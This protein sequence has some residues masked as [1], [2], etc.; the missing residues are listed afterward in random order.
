MFDSE[1]IDR[2][3]VDLDADRL[4]RMDK[5]DVDVQVL[6]LTTPAVQ[7]LAP[8]ASVALARD[9]NDLIAATVRRRPDRFDGFANSSRR[10]CDWARAARTLRQWP[11]R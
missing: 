5:A 10:Q 7:N 4:P 2:H 3:L 8:A 11:V 1:E 9:V 6:S